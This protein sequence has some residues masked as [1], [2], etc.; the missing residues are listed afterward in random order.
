MLVACGTS[1]GEVQDN[2]QFAN[3][4]V[5]RA[6]Q[7]EATVTPTPPLEVDATPVVT[8]APSASPASLLL[9]RGAP[10][11]LYTAADEHLVSVAIRDGAAVH[12]EIDAGEG[13]RIRAFDA[14]PAGD[15]VAMLATDA[16]GAVFL[17]I[18]SR[19]GAELLGPTDVLST[20]HAT[21]VSGE[22]S[23]ARYLVSWSPQGTSVLVSDGS[24]LEIVRTSGEVTRVRLEDV[25]GV[26]SMASLSPQGTRILYRVQREDETARVF[27]SDLETGK[28]RELRP[29]STGPGEGVTDLHWLPNGTGVSYV[30]GALD[31]GVI[32][33][34]QLFVY[35]L[36][37]ERADLV[38]TPGHGGPSA[39]ITEAVVSPD[40][41][42]VAYVISL[43]DGS[44]WSFHSMWVREL[45]GNTGSYQVPVVPRGV[46][47]HLA[48]VNGGLAWEQRRDPASPGEMLFIEPD[49]Y[50]IVVLNKATADVAT[51][52]ASPV[53]AAGATPGVSPVGT[54]GATPSAS[55]EAT[56]SR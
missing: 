26:L 30:R 19:E 17:T 15:R 52:G 51:P 46:V 16:E 10:D 25:D 21:P 3:E 6:A 35:L 13:Q 49:G 38:A 29:L 56:P 8:P 39:T 22:R 54:G 37:Q 23:T 14:S 5:T 31:R 20:A 18:F 2:R 7:A 45:G 47:G 40:G 34:G 28:T 36:G 9:S 43:L 27:V 1:P 33:H 55:P 32:L 44:T 41:Q 12:S 4:A 48:W 50:P 42:R 24:A 11:T 53:V